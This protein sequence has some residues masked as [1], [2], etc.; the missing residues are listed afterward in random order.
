[1]NKGAVLSIDDDEGLR[2]VLTHYFE[3]EGYSVIT[4]KDGAE[5]SEKL[6][7]GQVD[8]VLLDLVLPDTEG[9]SLIPIIRQATTAPIIVVSGKN[10]TTE[11]IICLEMGADDYLT[12]PFELRELKARVKAAIRRVKDNN[13]AQST[14]P[15]AAS[16]TDK[17]VFGKFTLDRDQYQVFD[18][19]GESIDVTI[20]EFQLLEALV[21]APKRPLSREQL[22]ERTRDGKFDIYDRAIDIQIGRI[23]KKLGEDGA[24]LIKTMRGVG[25]MYAPPE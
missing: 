19:D 5:A 2:V 7:S 9:T 1:M 24:K 25:Y 6:Q 4:A 18:E 10:D 14:A 23:R 11:K 21:S 13:K 22:F 12:K 8:V 20:G 17:I 16:E 15:D 3:A